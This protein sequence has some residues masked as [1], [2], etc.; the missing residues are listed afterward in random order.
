MAYAHFPVERPRHFIL[1]GTTNSPLYMN[2]QTGGRRFW[3]M[4]VGRFNIDWIQKH[5]DQLWAEACVREKAG[6][7]I[8]LHETLWPEASLQ[9]EKRREMDP[10]ESPLR[11]L[12]LAAPVGSDNKRRVSAEGIWNGLNI[13]L[14]RRDRPGSLRISEILHRL[15]FK[16]TTVR[17]DNVVQ[18]G[19]ITEKEGLLE[20][21]EERREP[22]ED[23][24]EPDL[25]VREDDGTSPF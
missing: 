7:S 22:G 17:V 8:R 14:E 6:E 10:W 20:L 2:D 5:R 25:G 21:K 16:R 9:Q 12:L 4:R 23:D 18:T 1:I 24:L 3:P 15:G 11:S 13:P 19:Y